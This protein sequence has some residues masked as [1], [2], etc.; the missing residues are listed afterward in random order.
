M[1]DGLLARV[2]PGGVGVESEAGTHRPSIDKR[3]DKAAS[4]TE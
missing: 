2:L 1:V 4:V 3:T